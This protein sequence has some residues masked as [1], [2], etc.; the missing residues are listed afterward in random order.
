VGKLVQA[1]P[2]AVSRWKTGESVPQ[3]LTRKRLL[4]L[5]YVGDQLSKVLRPE[6]ANLWI[7]SRNELLGNDTPAERIERGDFE[8]VLAVIEALAEGVV[9]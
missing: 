2:R 5:G 6:D 8:S 7:F 9:T 3:K 4:E 1:S